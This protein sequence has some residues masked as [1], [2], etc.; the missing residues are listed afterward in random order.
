M[1]KIDNRERL[2]LKAKIPD[3]VL[4]TNFELFDINDPD[5]K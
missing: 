1:N 3:E 5:D 2:Y 4:K